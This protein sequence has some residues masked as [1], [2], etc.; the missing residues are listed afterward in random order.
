MN[1]TNS[2]LFTII[3]C[4][5]FFVPPLFKGQGK[6]VRVRLQKTDMNLFRLGQKSLKNR[7]LFGRFEA[8]K[9]FVFFR[10]SDLYIEKDSNT[11]EQSRLCLVSLCSCHHTYITIQYSCFGLQNLRVRLS[12]LRG[13]LDVDRL[14]PSCTMIQKVRYLYVFT[15]KF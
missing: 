12:V 7:L 14:A 11:D 6:E 3:K 15:R 13:K 5:S 4:T 8:K 2:G 10:F 9:K 1:C